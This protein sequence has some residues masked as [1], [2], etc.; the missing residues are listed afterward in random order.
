MYIRSDKEVEFW[1][2]LTELRISFRNAPES[3][4]IMRL[5]TRATMRTFFTLSSGRFRRGPLI[6][7]GILVAGTLAAYQLAQYVI[8]GD[9]AGLAYVGLATLGG[10]IAIGIVN[11]WRNGVYLFLAWLL[12]EDF[13]RKFLG[14]NMAIYFAKDFLALVVFISFLAAY[15]RRKVTTFRPPF[16]TPL[17]I[18]VWFGAIQVFNPASPSVW[19]G[20]MG[21]KMF[22]YYV[23][24]VF[25][26]YAMLNSEVELRRFFTVNLVLALVI[27]SLG[28]A[29]SILGP[30][31]LNPGVQAEDLRE[32]SSL[33]RVAP[34]TG[35][36]AYRPT[37]VFVSAGRYA[38]FIGVAWPLVLGFSGYLLLRLEKRRALAFIAVTVTAGGAYLTASRGSFMWGMINA[39]ATSVA[40][41][42]GAPWRQGGTLR[43]IR[44][45]QRTA[46]GIGLAIVLLFIAYPD[47]LLSRFDIY[48]ETLT[49]S[50][51]YSELTF[52]S[53]NY[54]VQNF[55]AAFSYDR[56][57][58][59]YGIGT[60]SLGTQYVAR[61]FG[62]Q[63]L[64]VGVESGYGALVVEM[65]IVGLFLWIVMSLAILIS[66]WKVVRR[67]KGSRLFPVGFI[68]F[69]YAFYLLF[70]ATFE[71][72]QPYEDFLLNAFLWLLLGMLFRLP[73]LV[74]S[75]QFAPTAPAADSGRPWIR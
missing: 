60:T 8:S 72:M 55:L 57:P 62:A 64:P 63:R 35:A 68:I 36:V 50:S 73:S 71:G 2:R 40:F 31:F 4:I 5:G 38:N 37:S 49:P 70:P 61:I 58:Y 19:Y 16:L 7:F 28:I 59:G 14:N 10:L 17:L 27:I 43:A 54:P 20:L 74:P 67:L 41:V 12:F 52:R 23:P 69:W 66:A 13:A 9:F 11:N 30:S 51:P 25:I 22:F 39:L 46:L 32:L 75:A 65:G 3:L 33:Y 53:W 26:G 47:A 48:Q 45:I 6:S 21:F 56:W 24:L 15:R 34:V 42:W 44:A 29:Q 18:F 1:S